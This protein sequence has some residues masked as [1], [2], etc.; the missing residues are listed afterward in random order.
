[1]ICPYC[2]N[3][4]QRGWVDQERFALK[5]IPEEDRSFMEQLL[6]KNVIKLTSLSQS[7]R[8]IMYHCSECKKFIVDENEIEV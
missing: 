6:D 8:L 1:M 5:W 4:M 2:E 3:G 7:G